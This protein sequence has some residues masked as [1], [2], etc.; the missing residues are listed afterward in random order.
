[1]DEDG[2]I[3]RYEFACEGDIICTRADT[4]FIPLDGYTD[5]EVD[6]LVDIYEETFAF[7]D[8]LDFCSVTVQKSGGHLLIVVLQEDVDEEDNIDALV[9][10]GYMDP[11]GGEGLLSMDLTAE[12]LL[13]QGMIEK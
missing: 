1:M 8:E 13:E 3:Y 11:T 12:S 5:E 9:A 6:E 4:V 2:W 7:V 10:S